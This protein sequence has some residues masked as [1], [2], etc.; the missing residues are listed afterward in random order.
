MFWGDLGAKNARNNLRYALSVLRHTFGPHLKIERH[1]AGF[2]T[3]SRYWL[4]V[5]EF[6]DLIALGR[7]LGGEER[8]QTLRKAVDLYR[9]DF[10]AGFYDDWVLKEQVRLERLYLEALDSLA[11]WP[12]GPF[13]GSPSWESSRRPD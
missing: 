5:E 7:D 4:D 2:N 9:G 12:K 3:Q 8:F 1:Q 6:E 10:L 11:L 13:L